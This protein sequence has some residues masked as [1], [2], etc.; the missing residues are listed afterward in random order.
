MGVQGVSMT[1]CL[2]LLS[3]LTVLSPLACRSVSKSCG[4]VLGTRLESALS[5]PGARSVQHQ[6]AQR[7]HEAEGRVS[8]E[9]DVPERMDARVRWS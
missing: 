1:L 8:I 6:V 2:V 5:S 7:P 9:Y 3:L 4:Q